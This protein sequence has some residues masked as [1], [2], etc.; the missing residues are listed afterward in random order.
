VV[1]Y[2]KPLADSLYAAWPI[3]TPLFIRP[4]RWIT[5]SILWIT[6]SIHWISK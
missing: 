3:E 1:A 4:I 6:K 5:T 2:A